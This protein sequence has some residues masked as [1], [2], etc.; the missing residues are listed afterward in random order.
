MIV[1]PAPPRARERRQYVMMVGRGA[2]PAVG[3]VE[4]VMLGRV[5]VTGEAH[6]V[7][8]PF[9]QGE[10]GVPT[11]QVLIGLVVEKRVDRDVHH[12]DDQRVVRRMREYVADKLELALV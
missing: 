8:A 10:E 11:L 4:V 6:R 1:W 7:A 3:G 5:R 9:E 12:H 2:L